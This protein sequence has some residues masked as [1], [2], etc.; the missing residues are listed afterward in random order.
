M[1][2]VLWSAVVA[3]AFL[4]SPAPADATSLKGKLIKV[5]PEGARAVRGAALGPAAGGG[6]LAIWSSNADADIYS[7]QLFARVFTAK[8]K[9]NGK[10]VRYD[11]PLKGKRTRSADPG[12]PILLADGRQFLPWSASFDPST[13]LPRMAVAQILDG[14]K[15]KGKPKTLLTGDDASSMN[16]AGLRG[17]GGV[18]IWTSFAT[19]S[20][21]GAAVKPNGGVGRPELEFE[22]A[23]APIPMKSG[24]ARIHTTVDASGVDAIG[25]LFN[26]EGRPATGP[27]LLF[28]D[29]ST[30]YGSASAIGLT[31]G[32]L[33]AIEQTRNGDGT[34]NDY[35][36]RFAADGKRI[37]QVKLLLKNVPTHDLSVTE[38]D[39]GGFLMR[40]AAVGGTEIRYLSFDDAAKLKGDVVEKRPQIRRDLD[41]T[42]LG[43]GLVASPFIDEPGQLFVQF[44]VP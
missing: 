36:H 44:V 2:K 42:R 29:V 7:D 11:R 30:V 40:I 25:Q 21:Y 4:A 17:G 39:D 22:P 6:F 23:S 5:L 9:P 43:D 12:T 27:F 38:T 41:M 8:G 14:S 18:L 37:G 28:A 10:A 33:L 1:R 3:A 26:R 20:Q 19:G 35:A 32:Q 13:T 31:N 34:V 15:L 24:F 16:A